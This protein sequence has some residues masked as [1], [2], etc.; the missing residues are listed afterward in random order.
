MTRVAPTTRIAVCV[1]WGLCVFLVIN[2]VFGARC[3]LGTIE[4]SLT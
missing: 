2:E 3:F 1:G 4:V